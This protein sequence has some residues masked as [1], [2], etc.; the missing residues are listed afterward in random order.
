MH[1]GPYSPDVAFS[2]DGGL[3][4]A[5]GISIDGFNFRLVV[6]QLRNGAWQQLGSEVAD[7]G[8]SYTSTRPSLVVTSQGPFAAWT[9]GTSLQTRFFDGTNWTGIDFPSSVFTGASPGFDMALDSQGRPVIVF[10]S[11]TTDSI[12]TKRLENGA[13]VS[14]GTPFTIDARNVRIAL[15]P[16]DTIV[17]LVG[18]SAGFSSGISLLEQS[19]AGVWQA[20]GASPFDS[21]GN[22]TAGVRLGN[23]SATATNTVV[24]WNK[25]TCN[26]LPRYIASPP[27]Y[28]NFAEANAVGNDVSQIY[29]GTSIIESF[30]P[31]CVSQSRSF[32]RWTGS[33]WNPPVVVPIPH[34]HGEFIR[35]GSTIFYG[36]WNGAANV[37]NVGVLNMP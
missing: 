22:T 33:A 6:S 28:V 7:A 21:F 5:H 24:S 30:Q 18:T 1:V 12:Q 23:L 8:S 11:N 2:A 32:Q 37:A 3:Y 35:N 20:L 17:A 14:L 29:D 9:Q 34:T 31:D 4:V 19:P 16:N 27:S 25:E 10:V 15:R 26:A 36:Y 13:W